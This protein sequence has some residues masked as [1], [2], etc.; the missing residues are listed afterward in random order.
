MQGLSA[1]V[2][3]LCL[4]ISAGC[5][6]REVGSGPSA[7]G[8]LVFSDEFERPE[9]GD[10][11]E[12]GAGEAG[13]GKWTL[14]DGWLH[15]RDI[16]NDPLWYVEPLPRKVRVEF[17]ARAE[18]A[19]GD[20]KVEIFGDGQNHASGYILIFGGWKNSLDTIARLDEHGDDR[21]TRTSRKV[22]PRRIYRFA[23]E[24]RDDTLKWFVD[25]VQFMTYPDSVPLQGSKH[26]HFAFND[27]TAPVAFDNFRV[28]RLP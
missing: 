24:R 14:R 19:E 16:K 3:A 18:S 4:L 5:K 23:I 25:G 1:I 17:D 12:R 2:A 13:S 22:E 20:L 7:D 8:E 26:A 9:I 28:Y 15:G 11:W 10:S 27:W 21:K 6:T